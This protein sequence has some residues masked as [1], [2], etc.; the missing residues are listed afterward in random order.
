M[1]IMMIISR[2]KNEINHVEELGDCGSILFYCYQTTFHP[3]GSM[4]K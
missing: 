3:M 4:V 2:M 1:V